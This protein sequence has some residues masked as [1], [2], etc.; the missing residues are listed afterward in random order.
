MNVTIKIIPHSEQRYDTCGDWTFDENGDLEIRVSSMGNW[1]FESLVARHELDEALLCKARG[2]SQQAVDAFDL[3][4]GGD[5]EETGED[6]DAPYHVEHM[7]AYAG[8]LTMMTALGVDYGEYGA[9]VG[10][11]SA[12]AEE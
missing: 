7:I 2:I 8:E 11:L 6:P 5:Y 9:A 3:N 10:G 4:Y 1:K 12:G